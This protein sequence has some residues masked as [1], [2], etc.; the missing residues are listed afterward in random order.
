MGTALL[1]TDEGLR[2]PTLIGLVAE[3]KADA[4]AVQPLTAISDLPTE[5]QRPGLPG[6]RR[7]VLHLWKL[8]LPYI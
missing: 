8:M 6:W 1:L 7:R 4:R 2:S 5:T 3:A